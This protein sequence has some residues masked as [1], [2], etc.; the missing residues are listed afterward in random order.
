M[1]YLGDLESA[2]TGS[3]GRAIFALIELAQVDVE[4]GHSRPE[5]KRVCVES[6]VAARERD[7]QTDQH[8]IWT[9]AHKH[10]RQ[11]NYRQLEPDLRENKT[12]T[13]KLSSHHHVAIF[14]DNF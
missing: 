11:S 3:E 6:V 2:L 12:R 10:K 5:T 1:C 4:V 9:N 8:A 13:Q 14:Y 7:K